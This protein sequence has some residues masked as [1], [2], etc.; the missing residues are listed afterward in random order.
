MDSDINLKVPP[1]SP[2]ERG[3]L[4]SGVWADWQ[5]SQL[6]VPSALL[7]EDVPLP[8]AAALVRRGITDTHALRRYLSPSW[9][10]LEHP[11]ALPDVEKAVEYLHEAIT[12]GKGIYVVADYDVDG[13][14][15]AALLGDFFEKVGHKKYRLHIPNR[16]TEG[17]GVSELALRQALEGGY[18][19]FITADCGTKEHHRLALLRKAGLTIIV[20]DHHALG[21]GDVYPPA[22]AFVNPQRQD[23]DYSNPYLSGAGVVFKVLQAY[24][25]RFQHPVEWVW[26]WIDL[27]AVSLLA[28]I[29][30]LI[31]ENRTLVQLGLER[32]QE[33]PRPGLAALMKA[34]RL[35]PSFPLRSR[36]VVYQLVPRLNAPG[37]LK[38]ARYTLY[39]LL[40]RSLS[41]EVEQVALYLDK[42]NRHRQHLQEQVLR[43][44]HAQLEKEY[45]GILTG[46]REPPP[47][48]VVVGKDWGKGIV[49][50][51]A[52]KLTEHFHRPSVVLTQDEAGYL[53][54]SARSPSEFP[55]HDLLSTHC[56]P[57]LLK[58]GGHDRA[59]GLS[60]A[61]DKVERFREAFMA[62]CAA[63]QPARRRAFIDAQ[64][65]AE[66]LQEVRIA[67][68][69]DRF[70]PIGPGNEAPRFLIRGLRLWR[71]ENERLLF[72]SGGNLYEAHARIPFD[73]LKPYLAQM[74]EEGLPLVAT[75]RLRPSGGVE[76]RLRDILPQGY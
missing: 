20:L 47:A 22:D 12:K 43:A 25:E 52:A 31:G 35:D 21:E 24:V 50:L 3:E 8:V 28:D 68:W 17:Y 71:V 18:H 37:R 7:R 16:F 5:L 54:G 56:R 30:P 2:S 32:L 63:Q 46:Q 29:M 1:L 9:D 57:Y 48:F 33:A 67:S 60:L 41:K 26:E 53:T 51:V 15:S 27:V 55:L 75:P 4:L 45:P 36:Q 62:A 58:F 14:T 61:P 34:A 6:S 66:E 42:L 13:T 19:L 70:E 10:A 49:G 69:C 59:A 39:L 76:L 65:A 38:D 64:L 11:Y 72:A 74:K 40:Q 23:T 73:Q 44:A